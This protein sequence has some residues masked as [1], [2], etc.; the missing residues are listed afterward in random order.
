M[1][2][3]L[4]RIQYPVYNLG[5]G[6]RIGIWVQGC[7]LGCK[8]CISQTLWTKRNGKN[9]NIAYLVNQIAEVQDCFDGITITGG[10]PFEQYEA[11]IAFSAFIKKKTKLNI[12]VF[13]GFTLKELIEMYPDRLFMRYLDY[14]LDGRYMQEK[15]DNQ[16]ARGSTNQNLYRFID[17]QPILQDELFSSSKWSLYISK[18][19]QVFMTGIPKSTDL[20][21]ITKE[22]EKVGIKMRFL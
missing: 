17:G 21:N 18:E 9:V 8:G 2:W 20:E 1:Y 10:E 15:H 14:L 5:P 12:Y 7:S 6:V 19:K 4:N 13:S 16:N 3:R 11:L 22:L